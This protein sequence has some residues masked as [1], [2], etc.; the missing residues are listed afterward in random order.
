MLLICLISQLKDRKSHFVTNIIVL[1]G[2]VEFVSYA[3]LTYFAY[4]Y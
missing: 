2:P 3:S 4:V 1:W